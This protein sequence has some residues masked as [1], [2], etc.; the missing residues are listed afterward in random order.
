MVDLGRVEGLDGGAAEAKKANRVGSPSIVLRA[1]GS[2][3]GYAGA[4]PEAGF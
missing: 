3:G 4:S 2:N 1:A